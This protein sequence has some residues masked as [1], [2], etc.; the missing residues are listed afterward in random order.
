MNNNIPNPSPSDRSGEFKN[1]QEHLRN[2]V[3]YKYL[4]EAKSHRGLDE[5]VLGLNPVESKG[6]QSMGILHYLGLKAEHKGAL[7]ALDISTG[8]KK[9]QRA[10][11]KEFSEIISCLYRYIENI[12]YFLFLDDDEQEY[13]E[14]KE[15]FR[16]HRVRERNSKL[17]NDAKDAFVKKH[18]SLFCEVCNINF[19]NNYGL[20]GSRFIEAHHIKP[21]S[22]LKNEEKTKIKDLA[23]LC[24]NCHRMIHRK[25]YITVEEL[26]EIYRRPESNGGEHGNIL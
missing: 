2:E 4:F 8:I 6:Y 12:D 18:G 7:Y 5:G 10:N 11:E 20:R 21:V 16:S 14:G 17:V 26:K 24:P 22:Q 15:S 3:V 1:Y 13:P 25:P 19:E 23:M 9:L